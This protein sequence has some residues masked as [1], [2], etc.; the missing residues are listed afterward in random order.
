MKSNLSFIKTESLY[1]YFRTELWKIISKDWST[2][3]IK[4]LNNSKTKD[5]DTP[6]CTTAHKRP[7]Q[8]SA[9]NEQNNTENKLCFWKDSGTDIILTGHENW[10]LLFTEIVCDAESCP[11]FSL[12]ERVYFLVHSFM[13][14][15]IGQFLV[16]FFLLLKMCI[17]TQ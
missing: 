9:Y 3:N 2:S 11:C 7:R 16:S 10:T 8:H 15:L 17:E 13:L 5:R 12:F 14:S 4:K 1:S 6:T